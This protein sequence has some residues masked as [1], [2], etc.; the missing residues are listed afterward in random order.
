MLISTIIYLTILDMDE[1]VSGAVAKSL[2]SSKL[3]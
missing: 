2:I 3:I 1:Y